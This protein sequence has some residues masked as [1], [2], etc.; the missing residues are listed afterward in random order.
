MIATQMKKPSQRR[1]GQ[2]M[3][4]FLIALVAIVALFAGLL[5]VMTLS[6]TQTEVMNTARQEAGRRAISSAIVL[7]T[8][9]YIQ[10][11]SAGNDD[12]S[13]SVDD[14]FTH[15][16]ESAFLMTIVDSAAERSSDWNV[17]GQA[18]G[19]EISILRFSPSTATRLGLVQGTDSQTV[20][21][22]PAVKHL[23]YDANDIDIEATVWMP[24][25]TGIY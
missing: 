21:L 16:N 2:A 9:D 6:T 23:I 20:P 15:A 13:Y 1:R 25:T 11:W 7:D 22:L 4:E 10:E 12:S 14:E 5:Q 3:V 8:P 24:R 17:L 19:N 18:S